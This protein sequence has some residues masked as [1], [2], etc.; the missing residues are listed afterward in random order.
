MFQADREQTASQLSLAVNGVTNIVNFFGTQ[1]FRF[2]VL[3][4]PQ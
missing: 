4:Y 3:L 1:K 2:L